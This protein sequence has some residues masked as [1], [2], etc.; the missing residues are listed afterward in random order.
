MKTAYPAFIKEDDGLFIVYIPDFNG[1]TQ[2]R[3]F[4]DAIEMTRDYIGNCIVGASGDDM[5][6]PEISSAKE[7]QKKAKKN[8]AEEYISG[9]L[10]YVDVDV[11]AHRVAVKNLS[12]KKNCTLP[13]W[14]EQKAAAMGIN[15][16]QVLQDA[17]KE[18]LRLA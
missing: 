13:L 2:G 10:T 12:V 4:C 1:F 17:L 3:D 8:H 16:S 11:D 15:F 18:K 9:T 5:N 7:A 14:L 6:F